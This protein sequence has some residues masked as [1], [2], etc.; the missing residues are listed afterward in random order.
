MPFLLLKK[1]DSKKK[2]II[3]FKHL[4]I[5]LILNMPEELMIKLKKDYILGMYFGFNYDLKE[6][7]KYIDFYVAEDNV[8]KISKSKI[9]RINLNGYNFIGDEFDIVFPKREKIYDLIYIGNSSRRKGLSELLTTLNEL[10]TKDLKVNMLIINRVAKGIYN[11]LLLYFIRKKLKK[12]ETKYRKYISYIEIDNPIGYQLPKN[13]I[14]ELLLYSKALIL[15]SRDE[16]AARVVAE[17]QLMGLNIISYAKM[18]GATNNHLSKYDILYE[19][20]N[21]FS[22]EI[23]DFIERYDEYYSKK[24]I[25]LSEVYLEKYNKPKFIKDISFYFDFEENFL[26]EKLKDVKFYNSISSHN[27]LLPRELVSNKLSDE[28]YSFRKMYIFINYLLN[29]KPKNN[30]LIKYFYKDYFNQ[31]VILFRKIILKFFK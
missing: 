26:L 20:F 18:R 31:I 13:L 22:S 14:K 19:D 6:D 12:I 1:E 25:D 30:F 17:A 3:I 7:L 8:L 24:D 5:P 21:N 16:G 15:P 4:E 9:P 10:Y 27:M 29:F 2:G 28:I 23:Q 11:K